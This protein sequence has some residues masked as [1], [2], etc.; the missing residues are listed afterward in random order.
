MKTNNFRF[1]YLWLSGV[2]LLGL[3]FLPFCSKDPKPDDNGG[4]TPPIDITVYAEISHNGF[5]IK[6]LDYLKNTPDARRALDLIKDNI[7]TMAAILPDT[8]YRAMQKNPV[9]VEKDICPKGA[10]WY[11]ISRDWLLQNNMNPDKAKSV[12][13]CNYVNY[14]EWT[15]MHQPFMLL[16]E[17]CHQY[18]D[19]SL[20]FD[21]PGII[22]AFEHAKATGL[23]KNTQYH[24]GN[25]I[26]ST[27]AQAYALTNHHEYFAELSEAFWGEND[28]FPFNRQELKEYDPMGYHVLEKIWTLDGQLILNSY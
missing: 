3:F 5:T 20:T 25:G 11:H 23:Y 9:W 8:F 27:V 22:E 28:Y 24:H 14:V 12:E 16:H 18:H 4:T 6:I 21:H 26:Y 17:L 19:I 15:E 7:D 13:I 10:A 1:P 2:L